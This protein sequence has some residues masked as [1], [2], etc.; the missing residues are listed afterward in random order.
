M[1]G[2]RY[3][4]TV[5]EAEAEKTACCVFHGPTCGASAC[6]AWRWVDDEFEFTRTIAGPKATLEQHKLVLKNT[7]EAPDSWAPYGTPS[8]SGPQETT[9]HWRRP[10][11]G[12]RRGF[13]GMACLPNGVLAFEDHPP[14]EEI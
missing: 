8:A 2:D 11:T 13:C 6:M 3:L 12:Q 4:N 14:M 1:A 5:T 7:V 10:F 9:M